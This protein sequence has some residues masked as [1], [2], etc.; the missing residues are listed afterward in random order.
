MAIQ[1]GFQVKIW[2]S[3]RAAPEQQVFVQPESSGRNI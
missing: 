2:S 3:G 1:M